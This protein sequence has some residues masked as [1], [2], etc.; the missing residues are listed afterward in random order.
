MEVAV[1]V[2]C[3]ARPLEAACLREPCAREDGGHVEVQP[4]ERRDDDDSECRRDELSRSQREA[5]ADADGDD[6][7]SECDQDDQSVALG[8]VRGRAT[9]QPRPM[10]ITTGPR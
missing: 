3:E 1:G 9:V 2:A 5:G 6:R 10:P 7:L 4:P 8:E